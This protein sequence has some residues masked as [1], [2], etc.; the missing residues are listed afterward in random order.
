MNRHRNVHLTRM[1]PSLPERLRNVLPNTTRV[2]SHRNSWIPVISIINVPNAI[3][4]SPWKEWE[5][6]G[7]RVAMRISPLRVRRVEKN[8][9]TPVYTCIHSLKSAL[10][11]YTNVILRTS[12][13]GWIFFTHCASHSN[14]ESLWTSPG[15]LCA[16]PW[17]PHCVSGIQRV[18][19][20]NPS[21]IHRERQSRTSYHPRRT[22]CGDRLCS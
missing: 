13:L 17:S 1:K 9:Q 20:W 2:S 10:P 15:R 6:G 19:S 7:T 8:G 14:K 21:Y 11:L 16:C 22:K 5:S 3:N 4:L 12:F 18:S